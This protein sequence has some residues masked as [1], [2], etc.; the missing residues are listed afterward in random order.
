MDSRPEMQDREAG[1]P[2]M[3]L[4]RATANHGGIAEEL[5]RLKQMR[6]DQPEYAATVLK[7]NQAL[8]EEAE[9]G[10]LQSMV[11]LALAC[12]EDELLSWTVANMFRKACLRTLMF[13]LI[14]E[15]DEEAPLLQTLPVL[16][17]EGASF[18]V[19][20]MHPK[21]GR[22][23]LHSACARAQVSVFK[24][25]VL[26][27]ADIHAVANDDSMPLQCAQQAATEASTAAQVVAAG[28]I[29]NFLRKL[30]AQDSIQLVS[31][32]G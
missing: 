5:Q 13:D 12:R 21:N 19:N 32:R 1:R 15:A 23:P 6:W 24:L 16:F 27:G 11:Q 18:D 3:A 29:V 14:D 31:Y 26:H 9:A 8:V 7:H 10:R 4:F 25:L 30:G 17:T 2:R 22:T 28:D 20:T